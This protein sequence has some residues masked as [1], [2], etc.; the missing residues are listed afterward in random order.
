MENKAL[1]PSMEEMATYQTVAKKAADSKLFDK[2]G[3]E[4]GILSIMLMARELGIPPMQ[5]IMGGMNVIQGKVEIS[6]RLMN[7][8]IRQAGHKMEIVKCDNKVCEIKGIRSDT[9]ETYVAQYT[10]EDA[11]AAG[12]IRGGGG[13]DKFPSDMLFARCISRLARRLFA[14][15]IS[16]AYIEGEISEPEGDKPNIISKEEIETAEIIVENKEQQLDM[17]TAEQAI[18]IE[19]LIGDD[20]GLKTNM[21]NGYRKQYPEANIAFISDIPRK[22]YAPIVRNLTARKAARV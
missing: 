10:I 17:L 2:L 5:S 15:V 14:D 18:E 6:P 21:I 19:E 7:T 22:A 8:M 1:I 16:T 4:A 20:D 9:K 11:R 12:L 13:W 3:G